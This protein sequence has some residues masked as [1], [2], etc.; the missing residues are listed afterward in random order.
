MKIVKIDQVA[1][2]SGLIQYNFFPAQKKEEGEMPPIINSA[3]LTPAI[4]DQ[5]RNLHSRKGGYDQVEY[6]STRFNNVSRSLSIP[7]PVPYSK[8]CYAIQDNWKEFEYITQ[9]TNSFITPEPHSDGRIL[10]MDYENAQQKI[11]RH[12]DLTCSKK[13]FVETDISNFF[14]SIYSHSIPWAL[15]GFDEAKKQRDHKLW[16]NQ[17]DKCVRAMKRDET[18][19]VPIGPA[20]SNIISEAI[21]VRIDTILKAEGFVFV[22]F[23]DDYTAYFDTYE[24]AEKFIRRLG[25]ELSKYKLLLNAKKTV[26]E[27]L[28]CPSSPEWVVDLTTRVP[29]DKDLPSN[30]IRFL[31][32]A[33]EKQAISPDGSVIKYAAKTI[34]R[35]INDKTVGIVLKYLLGLCIKYPIL[36]PVLNT[37]FEKVD[38]TNGFVYTSQLIKILDEHTINKRSDAMAWIL[39][40]LNHFSQKIPPYT[41]NAIIASYDCVAILMLYLSKQYDNEVITFCNSLDKTDIFLLDQYWLLLYQL[42][43]DIK[44]TNPYADENAYVDLLEKRADTIQDA[45]QREISAFETLKANGVSFVHAP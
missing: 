35:E 32:Y 15:V 16:F 21:L 4:A 25:E 40:Y 8:L 13:F 9:S 36:I 38:T 3:T 1:L 11:E 26:I 17:I 42:F 24:E 20:T 37:L 27:Q 39:Y 28:P 22:R 23:I 12:V 5:L 10:V 33:V 30:L 43:L 7:H 44:I 31:D 45:M 18:N 29:K 41:A 34:V 14:P 2:L 6:R 19:G